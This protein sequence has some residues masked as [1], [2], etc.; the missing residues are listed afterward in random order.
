MMLDKVIPN[1]PSVV[2]ILLGKLA[3]FLM[4]FH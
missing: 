4:Q 1:K 2:C 3:V